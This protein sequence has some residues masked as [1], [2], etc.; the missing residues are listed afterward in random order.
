M[1][2]F[3]KENVKHPMK[4]IRTVPK[5]DVIDRNKAKQIKLKPHMIN[6]Q[7]LPP[8]THFPIIPPFPLITIAHINILYI[9]S[10][11]IA[12]IN[13]LYIVS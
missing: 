10:Y 11:T 5:H 8:H 2:A 9:V 13:I 6:Y 12:H 3:V 1:C 4:V 7:V